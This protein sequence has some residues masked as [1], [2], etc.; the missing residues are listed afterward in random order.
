MS[1]HITHTVLDVQ[2]ETW[3]IAVRAVQRRLLEG[4]RWERAA[5]ALTFPV[6]FGFSHV[7][8]LPQAFY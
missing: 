6:V 7:E 1:C 5:D 3:G 2:N 8:S 4:A